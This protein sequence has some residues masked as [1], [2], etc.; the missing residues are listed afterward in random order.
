MKGIYVPLY[1]INN[2]LFDEYSAKADGVKAGEQWA[3]INLFPRQP[4][5]G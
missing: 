3:T 2:R 5:S 1:K 4:S